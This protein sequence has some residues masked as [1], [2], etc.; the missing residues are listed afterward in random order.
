MDTL[1]RSVFRLCTKPN[2][3]Q[4]TTDDE[5]TKIQYF[6]TFLR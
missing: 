6:L 5:R 4:V 1:S 2:L 3:K